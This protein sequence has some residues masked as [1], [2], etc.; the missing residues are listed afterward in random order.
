M[1]NTQ[2]NTNS[3][4]KLFFLHLRELTVQDIKLQNKLETYCKYKCQTNTIYCL[5][6]IHLYSIYLQNVQYFNI[7]Q[8]LFDN[9]FFVDNIP[10]KYMIIS[11][12][13]INLEQK[14]T[15]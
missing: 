3:E 13:I 6:N 9:N 14:K 7:S 1:Y 5:K 15:V 10:Y 4:L 12:A 2:Q 8:L 11:E